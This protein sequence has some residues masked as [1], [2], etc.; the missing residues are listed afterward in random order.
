MS[1]A[2]VPL[3][4]QSHDVRFSDDAAT[5]RLLCARDVGA[6]LGMENRQT[7]SAALRRIGVEQRCQIEMDTP[8]GPQE[9][10]FVTLGG[11]I[12]MALQSRKPKAEP[13]VDWVSND[14]MVSVVQTGSYVVPQSLEERSLALL[15]ELSGVVAD[16]KATIAV[17]AERIA[18]DEPARV[19]LEEIQTSSGTFTTAQVVGDSDTSLLLGP[20]LWAALDEVFFYRPGWS[21]VGK[22]PPRRFRKR[23]V[24]DGVGVNIIHT[25][26]DGHRIEGITPRWT[27][28]GTAKLKLWLR[29][30]QTQLPIGEPVKGMATR[31]RGDRQGQLPEGW[32]R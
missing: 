9:M 20:N 18:E 4:F 3:S 27:V 29:L 7:V 10:T 1:T 31:K 6:C 15:A 13:F 24:L 28:K 5:V 32:T 22:R 26:V 16:Q 30:R 25:E 2:L 17:Q 21:G 11:A 12:K 14:V 23:F 8:G 19:W